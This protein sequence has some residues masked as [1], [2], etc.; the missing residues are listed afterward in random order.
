M[1]FNKILMTEYIFDITTFV[2]SG[3]EGASISKN[4]N[5]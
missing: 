5:L 2:L 3:I 1:M 4:R